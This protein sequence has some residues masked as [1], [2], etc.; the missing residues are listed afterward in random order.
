MLFPRRLAL[1]L[2]PAVVAATAC[3]DALTGSPVRQ[4]TAVL[5]LQQANSSVPLDG[6]RVDVTITGPDIEVPI[7]GSFRF[8]NDTAR[9]E[10][11]V[12]QGRNRLVTVA[13]YDSANT[14][15]GAGEAIVD[16]GAGASVR[17]PVVITPTTGQLPIIVR[18]GNTVVSVSPGSLTL[19]PG[20]SAALSVTVT[21]QD[22]APIAGAV[23]AFA[24]S[25]PALASVSVTGVVSAR[26]LG[27]TAV[28]V[29]AL[30]VAARVPVGIVAP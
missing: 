17:V 11:R 4:G 29:T 19:N 16:V 1:A 20:E 26:V 9:A 3:L 8:V 30:G 7:F 14:L 10:L 6:E 5:L 27:V 15:I 23:P 22:G 2:L 25:N 18:V 13:V 28:T 12:P 21:D 24:S